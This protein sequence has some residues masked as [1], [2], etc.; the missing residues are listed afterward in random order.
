MLAIKTLISLQQVED[1]ESIAEAIAEEYQRREELFRQDFVKKINVLR[2][3]AK[4]AF[5]F[6]AEQEWFNQ[7]TGTVANVVDCKLQCVEQCFTEADNNTAVHFIFEQ[8]VIPRCGCYQP[9][10]PDNYTVSLASVVADATPFSDFLIEAQN[11]RLLE[12]VEKVLG[13]NANCGFECGFDCLKD[14]TVS[15]AARDVCLR[16]H[17][18]CTVNLF[19]DARQCDTKCS[20]NCVL[21]PFERANTCLTQCGCGYKPSLGLPEALSMAAVESSSTPRNF[22]TEAF[23]FTLVATFVGGL[24]LTLRRAKKQST[25]GQL[26]K[27][28]DL[29]KQRKEKILD[30]EDTFEVEEKYERVV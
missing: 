19:Y 30:E 24:F 5:D 26:V 3:V 1:E 4:D 28:S 13:D 27:T 16:T 14:S 23:I 25:K 2:E 6:T 29:K 12:E 8:C 15:F 11:D 9:A 20:Q 22:Y 10:F 18:G 7:V 21:L 17:C